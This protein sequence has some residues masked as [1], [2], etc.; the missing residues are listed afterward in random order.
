ML[1]RGF[2]VAPVPSNPHLTQD[3]LS[4]FGLQT[5][6]A[7]VA[8][9]DPNT[10]LKINK[11]R[12]SYEGKVKAFQLP[13]RNRAVK[14]EVATDE[15][16]KP[17]DGRFL[18]LLE[19]ATWPE[20]EWQTTKV[21]G[22]ELHK[23]LSSAALAKLEKAMHM[24]PGPIPNKNEWDDLLGFEKAKPDQ[25][26]KK[27]AHLEN[28]K[29]QIPLETIKKSIHPDS[30]GSKANGPTGN[31]NVLKKPGHPANPNSTIR[32]NGLTNGTHV[33]GGTASPSDRPKRSGKKRR[34][35]DLSFDGYGDGFM[36]DD[37]GDGYTS[38]EGSRKST[39]S[40]RRKKV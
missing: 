19:L 30:S 39:T 26:S 36:D 22:K 34:Y 6:V 12:K 28:S 27:P 7:S 20:E 11:M 9:T 14:H 15:S 5:L 1:T 2:W 32:V 24:V 40:K 13:G 35:D 10:G 38:G 17:K 29:R 31:P 3:L 8:R 16:G 21:M 4:V 18:G 25:S 23:G 33:D 37:V